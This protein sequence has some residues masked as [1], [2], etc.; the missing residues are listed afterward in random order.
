MPDRLPLLITA[1]KTLAS[2]PKWVESEDQF[3]FTVALDIGA[4][5]QIGLRLRGK[6]SRDYADQNLTFQ[7][8]YLFRGM[9][10]LAPV[11]RLDWR[12]LKP[13]QNRNIGPV[14]WRLARFHVSH[15][16]PFQ[17][18]HDWMV[19]NGLPL[20]DNIREN[21]PI[22]APLVYDPD[23]FSDLLALMGEAFTIDGVGAIPAPPW[24]TPRLL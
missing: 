5:T 2:T 12:P 10:K 14:E 20:A 7:I 15:I 8:E 17:E 1:T 21:L 23:G 19:G 18:N 11:T 16:H 3:N 22:A 24:K 13:H 6:C 9:N 4:V